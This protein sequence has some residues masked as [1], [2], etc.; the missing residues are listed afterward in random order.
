MGFHYGK[1]PYRI[2][3]VESIRLIPPEERWERVKKAGYNVFFLKSRDVYI[4]LLTDSG[5]GALSDE[6]LAG[7]MLGDE[8]YA[9]SRS[10]ERFRDVV[11]GITGYPYIIPVHQGRGAEN[12]FFRALVQPGSIIPSNTHFDTTNANLKRVGAIPLDLPCPE[13]LDPDNTFPFKGNIDLEK[14]EHILHQKRDRIPFVM[15]TL[16]NNASGGHPAHPDHMKELRE[17]LDRWNLPLILDVARYAE[18]AYLVK[19]RDPAYTHRSVREIAREIFDLADGCLMSSKKDAIAPIGGFIALRDQTLYEKV[20]PE[21]IA[22][23]GY[24]TYGGLAGHDLEVLARGLQEALDETYL[25]Y[26]IS[27]IEWWNSELARRGIPVV[28][29]SGGHAVFV[30]SGELFSHVPWNKFP[31]HALA[32]ALYCI[33]G[34]R[35]VEIGSLMFGTEGETNQKAPYEYTR[36]AL[37]RRVYTEEHLKWVIECFDILAQTKNRWP[38]FRVIEGPPILRHFLARLEPVQPLP[39]PGDIPLPD[40]RAQSEE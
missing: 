25:H 4:D 13:A 39:I 2:K 17:L 21:L 33:G 28:Q 19:Y 12:V 6:Q 31:G 36:L 38:G 16:T 8:S 5:T 3:A 26:R 30:R 7:L 40:V 23:E 18:N 1:I 24:A 29:P 9:G 22:S 20:L 15:M 32:I 35:S 11:E 37:P 14:L 34:I 27:K 10:F